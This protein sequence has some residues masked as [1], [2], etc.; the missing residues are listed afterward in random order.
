ML[1]GMYAAAAGM[2]AQQARLDALSSDIANANTAG[3]KP[4]RTGFRDLLYSEA[5]LA[6]GPGVQLGA[7]AAITDLGRA[8]GQ[9]AL[10]A[11]Q[12]PLDLALT[13]PG[14]LQVTGADGRVYRCPG[15]D[16]EIRAGL[17]HVVSWPNWPGGE[18]ER[19]HWHTAC[20]RARIRRNPG[21]T[22]Y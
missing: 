17:P 3:Y 13:G 7:G 5:G 20:W 16:Q 8:S 6:T 2:Y 14:F 15:C 22:R 4:V 21:R 10:L 12:R 9:G 11:T 1:E 18:E 19:R